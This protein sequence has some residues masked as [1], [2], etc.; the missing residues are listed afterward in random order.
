MS[1]LTLTYDSE[2]AAAMLAAL[3]RCPAPLRLDTLI[4]VV[5]IFV[6]E[7]LPAEDTHT[8]TDGGQG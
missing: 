4:V 3:M 1:D 2:A 6:E 5:K 8:S 7:R